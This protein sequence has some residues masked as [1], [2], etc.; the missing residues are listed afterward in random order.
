MIHVRGNISHYINW[1]HGKHSEDYI[2]EQFEFLEKNILHLNYI[3]YQSELAEAVLEAAKE[4][5]Y[6]IIDIDHKL[7][8]KKSLVSQK[9]GKRWCTS[10]NLDIYKHV[11][12]NALVEKVIFNGNTAQGISFLLSGRKSKVY[13]RKG[14][15]LSTGSINTPKILQLS[16]IGPE[17]LLKSLGIPVV[18]NLPVGKNLQD[19]I[20]TGFDFL[21]FNKSMSISALDMINP[22]HVLQYLISGKGPWTTPGCEVIGFLSTKN[23]LDPDLQFMV[24]PVGLSSDRGSLLR[25]NVNIKD[26]VFAKYFSKTFDS[27]V[28]TIL[29]VLLH[30]KSRG[31]VFINS[32]DPKSK[33]LIDPNYLSYKEDRDTLING[34]KLVI[35]FVNT[36][37]IQDVGGYINKN[38]FPGCEHFEIFSDSYFDCYIRH[39][40]LTI[41]HPVGTCAMGLPDSKDT[42]VDTSFAVLGVNKLYVADASV[43]PTLPSGNINAAVAMM[44]S[45]FFDTNIRT[46]KTIPLCYK[47]EL[48]NEYLFNI[49]FRK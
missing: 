5:N 13:A 26:E 44:A 8:F 4:L 14:V 43:L 10:D 15:I 47:N 27:Y 33:P 3:Q 30:P 46:Q 11:I 48:I 42:V 28:S 17:K 45:V 24:L 40:T 9:N 6:D 37:A 7:G 16:G 22:F 12:T 18:I 41:Y 29:P 36:K 38:H 32:R 20:S 21:I 25:H 23:Q 31:H 1:F 2:K 39:I 34:L 49:C 19:H 35:K